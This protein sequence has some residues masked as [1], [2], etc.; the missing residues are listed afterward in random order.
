MLE[1]L[2]RNSNTK[3]KYRPDPLPTAQH[4]DRPFD[5]KINNKE[6]FDKYSMESFQRDPPVYEFVNCT[7]EKGET[8]ILTRDDFLRFMTLCCT[9]LR[10]GQYVTGD[11]TVADIDPNSSDS[12]RASAGM[13]TSLR[14][15][16]DQ[17]CEPR[18]ERSPATPL[19]HGDATVAWGLFLTNVAGYWLDSA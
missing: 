5:E 8:V 6:S 19:R 11:H 3:R 7:Y 14:V 2:N 9:E 15:T 12:S 10:C 18:G 13:P 16:R 1:I 17:R 4:P